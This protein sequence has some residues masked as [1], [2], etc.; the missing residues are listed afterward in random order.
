[1]RARS[2]AVSKI[3][4]YGI[5]DQKKKREKRRK[6]RLNVRFGISTLRD[7]A[8]AFRLRTVIEG[9]I[10]AQRHQGV[11][12]VQE[13]K[14]ERES[15]T[16]PVSSSLPT[17]KT[18]IQNTKTRCILAVEK[19]LPAVAGAFTGDLSIDP[20]QKIDPSHLCFSLPEPERADF[21][22]LMTRSEASRG[23]VYRVHSLPPRSDQTATE[24]NLEKPE[25]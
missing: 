16:H 3:A 10:P 13:L 23:K 22:G 5:R 8:D 6:A 2:G 21:F 20:K 18:L 4:S 19:P 15:E 7:W 9:L 12:I 11:L 24:Q 25:L 17:H 1:M 14:R